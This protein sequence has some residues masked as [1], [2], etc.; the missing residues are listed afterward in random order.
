MRPERGDRVKI[1]APFLSFH[2]ELGWVVGHMKE[3]VIV[4]TDGGKVLYCFLQA[5]LK[6]HTE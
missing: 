6:V 3:L 1:I 2:H 5:L 4:R